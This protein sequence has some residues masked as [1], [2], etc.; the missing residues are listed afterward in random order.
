VLLWCCSPLRQGSLYSLRGK[1][2]GARADCLHRAAASESSVHILSSYRTTSF[3]QDPIVSLP[4]RPISIGLLPPAVSRPFGPRSITPA[5]SRRGEYATA[6]GGP[7]NW[8]ALTH[9][10]FYK[11][12][13]LELARPM[14]TCPTAR[15]RSVVPRLPFRFGRRGLDTSAPF[16]CVDRGRC[17][18]APDSGCRQ[19]FQ[20][21]IRTVRVARHPPQAAP[22][23]FGLHVQVGGRRLDAAYWEPSKLLRTQ[24]DPSAGSPTNFGDLSQ[25]WG[26]RS[27]NSALSSVRHPGHPTGNTSRSWRLKSSDANR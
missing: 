9:L 5:W 23:R 16:R 1:R 22:R 18:A 27:L 17:A 21:S 13:P 7:R 19:L 24:F 26:A 14:P 4:G 3:P 11:F 20:R 8:D 6:K 25:F 12:L 10:C 2:N 15:S